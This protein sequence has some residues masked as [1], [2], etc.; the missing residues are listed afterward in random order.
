MHFHSKI[1]T[2]NVHNSY[3]NFMHRA[4]NSKKDFWEVLKAYFV[5]IQRHLA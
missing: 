4:I 2:Q 3:N 5:D 1:L